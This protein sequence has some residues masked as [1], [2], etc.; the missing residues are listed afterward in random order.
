MDNLKSI[1]DVLWN[2][3]DNLS[4]AEIAIEK[5]KYQSVRLYDDFATIND[6]HLKIY[7]WENYCIASGIL[8]D[9]AVKTKEKLKNLRE[10]WEILW[11]HE[12][13]RGARIT[14]QQ[15]HSDINVTDCKAKIEQL[16]EMMDEKDLQRLWL[17]G[18][19]MINCKE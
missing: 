11:D 16:M 17:M 3:E 13:K 7:N 10:A 14:L 18:E 5:C 8:L 2:A 15:N 19:V 9:Y 6:D 4:E 1:K 12:Q